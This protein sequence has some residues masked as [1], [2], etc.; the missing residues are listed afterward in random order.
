MVRRTGLSGRR[1]RRGDRPGGVR[2]G[3]P[4][5]GRTPHRGPGHLRTGPGP[6]VVATASEGANRAVVWGDFDDDLRL[7]RFNDATTPAGAAPVTIS[8][9]TASSGSS[10]DWSTAAVSL[11]NGFALIAADK[12]LTG[13]FG[14]FEEAKSIDLRNPA[15]ARVPLSGV[16]LSN[17]TWCG[18]PQFLDLSRTSLAWNGTTFLLAKDCRDTTQLFTVSTGGVVTAR[19]SLAGATDVALASAGRRLPRG[20]RDDERRRQPGRPGPAAE[21]HRRSLGTAATVA[22]WRREPVRPGH[23]GLR[24]GLPR[25]VAVHRQRARPGPSH[26]P[27]RRRARHLTGAGE[28]RRAAP[29]RPRRRRGRFVVRGVVGRSPATTPTSS[30]RRSCPTVRR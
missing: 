30:V 9:E 22:G 14:F 13:P 20:V 2:P 10:L 4:A 6:D 5:G 25:R 27:V 7:D 12:T 26:D 15:N 18:D 21:Q 29:A 3:G 24:L 17:L 28:R 1:S 19:G 8:N 23:G 11:G 16:S